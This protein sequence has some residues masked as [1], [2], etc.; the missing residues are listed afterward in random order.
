MYEDPKSKISLLEK[1]L[2]SR[3]DKVT[4]KIRRH[5]LRDR[6]ITVNPNWDES[7]FQVTEEEPEKKEQTLPFKILI[8]SIIFFIIAL[9]VVAYNFWGGGNL[10]SGNNIEVNVKAPISVSG[11]EILSYELEIKNNNNV[12]LSGVD[13]GITFPAGSREVKDTSIVAKRFQNYLGDILPGKSIKKNLDVVLFGGENEKKDIIINL[14]YKIAGSNSSFNK[15]KIFSVLINSAPVSVVVTGPKEVNT[16]QTIQ[17]SI[18]VTS[19]SPT[20]LKDILLKIEYPF[21][22]IF[23]NSSPQTF[24]KNN[25][26]LLGDLESGDK[27]VI[28]FS[29]I[30]NGQEG[31]ERGFNFSVGSQAKTDD[32]LIDVP[33]LSSFS[34]VT[35]RRPFVSA[36]ISF[37]GSDVTE[38][39]ANS[40]EK[41][42]TLIK[43]Q[44]NLPY[45]VSDVSIIV[46]IS[47]NSIDKSSIQAEGGFYRSI[48]NTIIFNKTTNRD[49]A[50]LEPGQIGESKFSFS[51]F[52]IGSV[53]GSGL[54]NPTIILDVLVNGKR[55]DYEVGKENVLFS[56]SRKIK[57]T[58]DPQ[59]FA[60]AEYYVGPFQNSGPMPPQ[61]EKETTYTITWTVTNPLNSISGARVTATLPPYIKWLNRVSPDKE[62]ISYDESTG[63][64]VWNVGNVSSGSGVFSPARE[65][66]FQ[67]SL[68]PSVS[69]IN[70][71][72]SLISESVLNAKDNFTLT[73]V[74]DAFS[75][76][77]TRLS[78]D[79]YF[80]INNEKVIQ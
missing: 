22:F 2:D 4:R 47:G 46:K 21:G 30:L 18:E 3:E 73:N 51:S 53:T 52:R 79:P 31:E 14:E 17:Y 54:T 48:D 70:S 72:P 7:E 43:W 9:V 38:Y 67:I 69:Q 40:G 64:L 65:V 71:S 32:S 58:S 25:L 16:N 24:L 59:L 19:N 56:D 1:V 80:K 66:S 8:G 41:I 39:I 13:M 78:N 36:D 61:A 34:S 20:V 42:E 29:G 75:D 23:N 50:L 10:V 62:K 11:G 44:N 35:I 49:L 26:W 45:Q 12:T 74:S 37:N 57:I 6:E 76:L 33:F 63:L 55:V 68:L 77:D 15:T 28:T 5:E 60:K 27:R